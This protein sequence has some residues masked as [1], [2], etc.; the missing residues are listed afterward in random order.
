[1]GV[2]G[3][4]RGKWGA[5]FHPP[6]SKALICKAVKTGSSPVAPTNVSIQK[7]PASENFRSIGRHSER[8]FFTDQT[9]FL[10]GFF[11]FMHLFPFALS[12]LCQ[13]LWPI[14]LE[15]V[16]ATGMALGLTYRLN[17]V[18][19]H[20]ESLLGKYPGAFI[21]EILRGILQP[22]CSGQHS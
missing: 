11:V 12:W 21:C 16:A 4:K 5:S 3:G 14:R 13:S 6:H 10:G 1:M 19:R 7:R 9:A 20:V 17:V 2:S 22:T 15:A 8:M 18:A